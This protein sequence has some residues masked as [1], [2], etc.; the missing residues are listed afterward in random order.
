MTRVSRLPVH[1]FFTFSASVPRM[2]F[3]QLR[4]SLV[5]DVSESRVYICPGIQY[6]ATCRNYLFKVKS[7]VTVD[8]L[9]LFQTLCVDLIVLF[10]QF[11]TKMIFFKVI[12]PGITRTT[13]N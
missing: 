1:V 7:T 2:D 5:G 3:R 11:L 13:Q 10:T 12:R 4:S 6:S 8:I 9:D